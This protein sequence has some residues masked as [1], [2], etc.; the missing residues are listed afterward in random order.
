[1]G[2]LDV[3]KPTGLSPVIMLVIGA[4]VLTLLYYI[5]LFIYN[6]YFHPLSKYPGPYIAAATSWWAAASYLRGTT[7]EDLLQLHNRYGPVARTSPNELSYIQP[8]QFKEIYGHKASG[9]QEFAKDKKYHSGL[10]G[11]PIIINADREEHAY[12]RKLL[13]NGFSDKALREQ[14]T[15]MQEYV[16]TLMQRLRE[17]CQDG[18]PVEI[19]AWYNYFTFDFIGLLSFGESFDCLTSSRFHPWVSI[20]F[21]LA[22]LMAFGQAISRLPRLLQIPAKLW[23]IPSSVKSNAVT[24]NQLNKEKTS[25]RIKHES[26]VPDFMDKLIDAYKGGKMSFEQ[27]TGN[28]SVLIVAGSETTATALAGFTY[29]LLKNPRV[30]AKVTSEIRSVFATAEDITFVN[31][32]QCKYLLACIEETLRI[33]PPSPQPH[34]R[35]IPEGGAVVNGEFLPSGTAVSVPLYAACRSAENWVDPASFIPERWLGQDPRFAGD[36]RDAF[37]PFSYGPRNCIGRNLA[38]VEMKIILARLLWHFDLQSASDGREEKDW[39]DQKVYLIWE[40]SPLWIKLVP[41]QDVRV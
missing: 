9:Q 7:P 23:V 17:A 1:M 8:A 22:K 41:V 15:V 3:S 18:Q 4:P 39:L 13:A 21:N 38:Y 12:V 16:E 26:P 20:F 19:S 6:I 2:L 28:A 31:A 40:K 14:E 25:H 24:L 36:K 37:Q 11:P 27:L 35:I 32:N 10:A 5:S 29:L 30:Y 34:Q 33:Y